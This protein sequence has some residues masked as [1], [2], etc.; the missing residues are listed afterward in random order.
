MNVVIIGAGSSGLACGIRLVNQGYDVTI[1]EKNET[2]GGRCTRFQENGVTFDT[3]PTLFMMP[4]T[5]DR[6]FQDVGRNI[7]DYLS[8]QRID[9]A[10]RIT[11]SDG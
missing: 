3:G 1:L 5:F 11:Y 8:I 6:L 7:S 4:D 9:P 10:Y 2:P